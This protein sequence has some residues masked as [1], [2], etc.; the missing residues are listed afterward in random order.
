[1]RQREGTILLVEDDPGIRES[2]ADCLSF[3]G[4]TVAHAAN[5]EEALQYLHRSPRP[6][7]LIVDLVMPVMNGTQFLARLRADP[8]LKDLPVVLMTAAMPSPTT[9]FPEAD[10]YLA[11]PFDLGDL[12]HV[13]ERYCGEPATSR[14][15]SA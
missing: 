9:A 13:V 10:E 3:E 6:R 12:L 2:I 1:M 14:P 11:K 7:V 8:D 5:G 15:H 4:Y